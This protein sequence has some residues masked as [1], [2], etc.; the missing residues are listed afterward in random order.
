MFFYRETPMTRSALFGALELIAWLAAGLLVG[1]AV[2]KLGSEAFADL[3]VGALFLAYPVYVVVATARWGGTVAK[4]IAGVRVVRRSD[5][6]APS[7]SESRTRVVCQ[8][9]ELLLLIVTGP[10]GFGWLWFRQRRH[11]GWWHD[12]RAGTRLEW[13]SHE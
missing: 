10:I 1:A 4:R 3:V 5:R 7:L 8:V 11:Q 9:L 2:E 13:S 6:L 12:E